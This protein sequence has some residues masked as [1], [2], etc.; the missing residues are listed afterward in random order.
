LI[1]A[2]VKKLIG[3]GGGFEKIGKTAY[4]FFFK[5]TLKPSQVETAPYPGFMTDWQPNWAVLM[6][7]AKGESL[8]WERVFENRFSY[9]AELCRV[10]ARIDFA[11][12]PVPDPINYFFFNF[13]PYKIYRQA[14]KI[15]GPQVLHGGVLTVTDLRAGAT[16]AIAALAAEGESIVIGRSILERGY[17][18]FVEKVKNLGGDIEKL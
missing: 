7:Q 18:N 1:E 17:E 2:F 15:I 12:I 8:I 14:I 9:V 16:L 11:K 6:T 4:K 3:C 5:D 10:G 13:D